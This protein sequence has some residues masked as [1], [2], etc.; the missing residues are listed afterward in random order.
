MES[1]ETLVRVHCGAATV[2]T[3]WY[4]AEIQFAALIYPMPRSTFIESEASVG[5]KRKRSATR[6]DKRTVAQLKHALDELRREGHAEPVRCAGLE[7]REGLYFGGAAGVG[8]EPDRG[9]QRSTA[10][11]T[12]TPATRRPAERKA[13][14]RLDNAS[15][16]HAG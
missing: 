16:P 9:G 14:R 13:E 5:S 4:K 1:L 12:S 7:A 3:C 8:G 2:P 15:G 6:G 10:R 11:A